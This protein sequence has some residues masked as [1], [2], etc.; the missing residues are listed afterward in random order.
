MANKTL[1]QSLVGLAS[2]K[3]N[4]RNEAG[5]P[6]YALSP[7]HALAQ[8]A[9]TGCL[10]STFY[11]SAETQLQKVLQLAAKADAAFVAKTAVYC[12]TRGFM[13][14]M[15]ALLCATLAARDSA[16]LA[17]IFDRVVD[18]GKMLRNF[19]Q[20]VRS[21]V[22]GRKSLGS[23]PKRLVQRWFEQ[24][25]DAQVFRAAVGQSPSLADVIKMVHPRP[26]GSAREALYGWLLGRPHN[27]EALP[28]LVRE[29]EAFKRGDSKAA[30]DVPFQMLTA[31]DLDR[32]AWQSIARRAPWQMTRMN[33]NTFAR[34]GVYDDRELTREITN[35][36]RNANL[37]RRARCFPYQ[38][39]TAYHSADKA[40]P[41]NVRDALQDAME[42]ATENVPAIDGRVYVCP[43]VARGRPR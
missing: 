16:L 26:D 39:L 17:R 3:S 37:V 11:A 6:A 12:R 19:V 8:Y 43:D 21:G 13:K 42:V 9:V 27:A 32:T 34:H 23:A 1:F 10:S 36:L 29:F 18:D 22:A 35:R 33:L 7:K 30:P 41:A 20:I 4:T 14:D 15:P 28:A 5:G 31:L 2:L 38:L 25:N 24:R 40:V